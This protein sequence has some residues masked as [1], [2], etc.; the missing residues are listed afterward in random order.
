[1]PG[2]QECTPKVTLLL[3]PK[4]SVVYGFDPAVLLYSVRGCSGNYKR[5]IDDDGDVTVYWR[6]GIDDGWSVQLQDVGRW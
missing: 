5:C 1:V 2:A 4:N 6:D 3:C